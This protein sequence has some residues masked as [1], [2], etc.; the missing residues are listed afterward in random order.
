V[1]TLANSVASATPK[2]RNFMA[3]LPCER[4]SKRSCACEVAL[5]SAL[6][7]SSN[8]MDS[9]S[10]IAP[11]STNSRPMTLPIAAMAIIGSIF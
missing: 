11:I 6:N 9:R 3:V 2:A 4:V 8:T 5:S 7:G 1:A 10:A